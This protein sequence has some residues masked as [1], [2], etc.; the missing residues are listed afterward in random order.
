MA[1]LSELRTGGRLDEEAPD[2]CSL[3]RRRYVSGW[4]RSGK[5][6]DDMHSGAPRLA[7]TRRADR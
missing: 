4:R 7:V 5:E 2:S 3:A 6:D 1:K